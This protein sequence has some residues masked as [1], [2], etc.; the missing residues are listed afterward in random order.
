MVRL[1]GALFCY[2]V[3]QKQAQLT[4]HRITREAGGQHRLALQL[5]IPGSF[6][7]SSVDNLLCCHSRESCISMVYDVQSPV[8]DP[9][10]NPQPVS[11][12]TAGEETGPSPTF[13]WKGQVE[14]MAEVYQLRDE[15][16]RQ[17]RLAEQAA[18]ASGGDGGGAESGPVVAE[19][20][21]AP[22]AQA[23]RLLSPDWVLDTSSSSG[24][25][26]LW[27]M[28]VSLPDIV[29]DSSNLETLLSFLLRRGQPR[30]CLL[31]RS[32]VCVS[33]CVCVCVC[34]CF[35]QVC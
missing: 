3:D 18:E 26:R 31:G 30:C 7:L 4:L 10:I 32:R 15:T 23:W 29:T 22:Y 12:K 27:R 20:P 28:G 2:H 13:C 5:Y 25:G 11:S 8:R 35:I 6:E 33:V 21:A 34:V 9:F 19:P 17:Q 1:Y 16:R 24:K 14:A